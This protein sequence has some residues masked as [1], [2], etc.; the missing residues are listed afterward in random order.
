[1]DWIDI[2]QIAK[3][4][5]YNPSG[6][7]TLR[8]TAGEGL[9]IQSNLKA[10]EHSYV[11][12]GET[13]CA[14]VVSGG[15]VYL[16]LKIPEVAG[17]K[18]VVFFEDQ[19]GG[20]IDYCF[21]DAQENHVVKVPELAQQ[22][23]FGFRIAGPGAM[24]VER[25]R[26][27]SSA[28]LPE[29]YPGT[30]V[31]VAVGSDGGAETHDEFIVHVLKAVDLSCSDKELWTVTG[32]F[33]VST[34][35]EVEAIARKVGAQCAWLEGAWLDVITRLLCVEPLESIL[36]HELTRQR[37]EYGDGSVSARLAFERDLK[38]NIVKREVVRTISTKER[39]SFV[40]TVP[41]WANELRFI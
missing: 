20:R 26:V 12:F 14:E 2:C 29:V 11:T 40:S 3:S 24:T 28:G 10:G 17:F 41:R 33:I 27:L 19:S 36:V 15:C 13:S 5:V 23:R 8:I 6:S 7:V 38:R 37:I 32:Q 25:I 9:K 1:M 30:S 39:L 16:Q 34:A 4:D 21:L 22:I 18:P 31:N 35:L